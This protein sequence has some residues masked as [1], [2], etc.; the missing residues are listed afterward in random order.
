MKRKIVL[1]LLL[2]ISISTSLLFGSEAKDNWNVEWTKSIIVQASYDSNLSVNVTPIPAQTQGYLQG[3]PF[4]IEDPG[5]S[6]DRAL[7]RRIATWRLLSNSS[8]FKMIV[9]A[10]ALTHTEDKSCRLPYRLS[11][12]YNL[13][14]YSGNNIKYTKTY[15]EAIETDSNE[16]YT[17]V[18]FDIVDRVEKAEGVVFDGTLSVG[19]NDGYI[20]F[21]FLP[22]ADI[23]NAPAGDYEAQVT[24]ELIEG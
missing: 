12:E 23:A 21:A 1:Y 14:Y 4:N 2:L 5:V 20:Y 13:G 24:I 7:G 10:N 17:S 3:M 9:K 22:E 11:F 18:T 19:N 6:P 8:N 15:T 16:G